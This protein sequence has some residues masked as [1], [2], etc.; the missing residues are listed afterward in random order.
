MDVLY[1][2]SVWTA[3]QAGLLSSTAA[4]HSFRVVDRPPVVRVLARPSKVSALLR[5]TFQLVAL[6]RCVASRRV[7]LRCPRSATQRCGGR[8]GGGCCV[9]RRHAACEAGK[10]SRSHIPGCPLPLPSRTRNVSGLPLAP[11]ITTTPPH[12][13]HHRHPSPQWYTA[14]NTTTY[15]A[16]DVAAN[17]TFEVLLVGSERAEL[18]TWHSPCDEAGADPGCAAACTG[19]GCNYT[20]SLDRPGS[21]TLQIRAR[22]GDTVSTDVTSEL[23][24]CPALCSWLID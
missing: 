18:S 23:V 7:W 6:V 24:C 15:G 9:A 10:C 1:T 20:F 21:Q 8:W 3:D 14:L 16:D 12:Y 2:L 11:P 13:H 22:V 17:A 4:I 19:A 5:P